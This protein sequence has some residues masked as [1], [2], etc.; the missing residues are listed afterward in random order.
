M[1]RVKDKFVIFLKDITQLIAFRISI[2]KKGK[3]IWG[4]SPYLNYGPGIRTL[5]LKNQIDNFPINDFYIYI[6][7]HWPW[8]DIFFYTLLG[9]LLNIK[10]LFNQNGIFT[11]KY[12]K[13]YKFH[14][15]ILLFGL[16]NSNF[17]IYQSWFCYESL[18]KVCPNFLKNYLEEKKFCRLLNPSIKIKKSKS[19]FTQK[20]YR[21]VICKSFDKDIAYYSKYLYKLITKIYKKHEISEIIIIG[22]IKKN[23]NINELNNLDKIKKIRIF[24]NLKNGEILNFLSPGAIAIHL[25]YGDACPNFI[26][27]AISSGVPC[28]VND[29]GGAKEIAM[30]ASISSV[31]E[32]N[33]NGFLMPKPVNVIK[34][35]E[36]IILNYQAFQKYAEIRAEKISLKKYVKEHLFILKTI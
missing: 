29:E 6:Q 31:N 12:N 34:D 24:K 4:R 25:N 26:A 23:L 14:N 35:I 20:K 28:I 3:I 10:I 33:I 30:D 2:K 7:S 13:N 18:K 5:R 22:D 16:L 21:I 15:L 27:E 1:I 32:L 9:K 8:Y 17:I 36:K 19:L 11:E